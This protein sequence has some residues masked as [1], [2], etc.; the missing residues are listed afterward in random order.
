MQ[1]SLLAGQELLATFALSDPVPVVM[2]A[3]V[4][5]LF[6]DSTVDAD[7]DVEVELEMEVDAAAVSVD[8]ADVVVESGSAICATEL[9]LFVLLFSSLAR[10]SASSRSFL[11]KYQTVM[12]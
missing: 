6:T 10:F 8:D 4:S 3:G 11:S 12:A 7:V 2:L 1:I 9:A 5:D